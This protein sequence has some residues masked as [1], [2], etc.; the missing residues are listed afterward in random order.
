MYVRRAFVIVSGGSDVVSS[1]V[2]A[3]VF[4]TR[5]EQFHPVSAHRASSLEFVFATESTGPLL[6]MSYA[7][8]M[9]SNAIHQLLDR[10]AKAMGYEGAPK[11]TYD[12]QM[13]FEEAV[14]DGHYDQAMEMATRLPELLKHMHM[15]ARVLEWPILTHEPFRAAYPELVKELDVK[16]QQRLADMQRLEEEEGLAML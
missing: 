1:R 3:C 2:R 9:R 7:G 14:R 15:T 6:T 10:T 5:R 8:T 12:E 16:Q 11:L 13:D 4:F